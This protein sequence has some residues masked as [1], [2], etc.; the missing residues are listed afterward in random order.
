MAL[1]CR[2]LTF[3]WLFKILCSESPESGGAAAK[4]PSA[5]RVHTGDSA[6]EKSK[7]V[8]ARAKSE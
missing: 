8:G 1:L 3:F 6:E 7:K 4:N 5:T 2:A